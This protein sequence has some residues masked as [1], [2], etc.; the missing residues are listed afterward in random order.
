MPI[1]ALGALN[2]S[3]VGAAGISNTGNITYNCTNGL[4]PVITRTAGGTALTDG[5]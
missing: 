3:T 4:T 5:R 1:I 2:P